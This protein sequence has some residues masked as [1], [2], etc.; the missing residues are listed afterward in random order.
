MDRQ[1][2]YEVAKQTDYEVSKQLDEILNDWDSKDYDAIVVVRTE[3]TGIVQS[4]VVADGFSLIPLLHSLL[5]EL[6][7]NEG[8][9]SVDLCVSLALSLAVDEANQGKPS[10]TMHDVS[11]DVLAEATK[12]IDK[13]LKAQSSAMLADKIFIN[14]D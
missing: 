3:K 8:I 4:R 13:T 11:A 7:N 12:R 14:K 10:Q 2:F 9:P 1:K 5:I 6:Q